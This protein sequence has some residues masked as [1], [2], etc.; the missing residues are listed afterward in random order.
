MTT[1]RMVM[2]AI[3]IL[4]EGVHT[5]SDYVE[6]NDIL[7]DYRRE[8]PDDAIADLIDIYL[9]A[10]ENYDDRTVKRIAEYAKLCLA[11]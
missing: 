4:Y 7:D 8:T 2:E 1:G 11:D 5:F 6:A 9:C 10:V 3:V